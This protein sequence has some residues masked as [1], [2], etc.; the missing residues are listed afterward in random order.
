MSKSKKT[1][2]TFNNKP[3]KQPDNKNQRSTDTNAP[4]TE[5]KSHWLARGFE[6][7]LSHL[8]DQPDSAPD[9]HYDVVIV[10]SGYGGRWRRQSWRVA[11]I[12]GSRCRSA[13][14]SE[15]KS[16]WP[17]C[18][19]HAWLIYHNTSE[20]HHPRRRVQPGCARVCS[21]SGVVMALIPC[22]PTFRRWLIDQCRVMETPLDSV[23]DHGWPD[24]I[25]ADKTHL[26][27]CYEHAR[28]RLGARLKVEGKTTDNT[29]RLHPAPEP[30]K[31]TALKKLADAHG[32][33][34]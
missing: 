28:E 3:N 21:I 32:A 23:F 10:G 30:E 12:M 11:I 7:L 2:K 5:F 29:I 26:A 17:V 6:Q 15:V 33:A 1:N 16:T 22:L 25:K 8:T 24:R 4:K 20:C 19:L 31:F 13:Y 14:W 9:F 18:F 34:G 27:T